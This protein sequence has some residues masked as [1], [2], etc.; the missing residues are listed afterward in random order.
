M[1][2][3]N[4][5]TLTPERERGQHLGFEERCSIKA[6]KKLGLSLRKIADVINCAAS[7]VLNEL[8][9][10]TGERKGDRG[11]FPEYSAQ[12][13]HEN[14]TINRSRSHRPSLVQGSSPFIDWVVKQVKDYKWSPDACVG[15]AKRKHL[16]PQE[17]VLC[18]KTL[19]NAVWEGKLPISP[20]DLPEALNRKPKK[21]SARK[22]KR[23][24]G[25][26]IDLRPKEAMMRIVCGH[27]EID[28]V[29]GHR[30]GKASVVLTL[31]E[32]VTDFYIA[33]KIPGKNSASVMAAM[34]VLREEFGEEHF[35]EL[36][37]TIT[38]D[39]GSEFE[40]L[41]EL[42]AYGVG[43]FFAHPYSSW[44]RAQNERHNR[45][46]RRYIPKAVS[47]DKYSADQILSFADEMNG[48]PRKHLGYCTPEEL[49][50]EF[51]DQV[52]SVINVHIA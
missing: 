32:K 6:C 42:E 7:T 43:V 21:T 33:I 25:K 41:K 23:V 30:K 8:R 39:N 46:F 37:K 52:Y 26:S 50:D 48:L 16:F 19:Y 27:W 2:H 34:E 1:D 15:Y 35:A 45:I 47:I 13:G 20:M 44:E 40:R 5:T 49:F 14:Y 18:T 31:V 9:R 24:L 4:S 22:N 38:A 12:R 51:L 11:R 36:F 3:I 28:T 10:G 17:Q 29:I